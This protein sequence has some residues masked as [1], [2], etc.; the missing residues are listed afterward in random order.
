MSDKLPHNQVR[1]TRVLILKG[2][3]D[4]QIRLR[5]FWERSDSEIRAGL[6]TLTLDQ[7]NSEIAQARGNG[8]ESISEPI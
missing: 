1:E 6:P 7:I 5:G 3:T 4:R 8:L 2:P